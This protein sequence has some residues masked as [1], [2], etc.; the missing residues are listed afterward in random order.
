MAS[1]VCREHALFL[2]QRRCASAPAMQAR[3]LP[4]HSGAQPVSPCYGVSLAEPLQAPG[5]DSRQPEAES[6]GSGQGSDALLVE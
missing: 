1:M 4:T 5:G 2:P 3:G 6:G